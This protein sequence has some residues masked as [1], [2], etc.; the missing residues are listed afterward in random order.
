MAPP[1]FRN[2]IRQ[3]SLYL[4]AATMPALASDTRAA[5][6]QLLARLLTSAG[7]RCE[8]DEEPDETR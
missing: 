2:P 7:R 6:V 1:A 3:L 8:I 4:P 5:V